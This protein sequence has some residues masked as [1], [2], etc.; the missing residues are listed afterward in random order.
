MDIELRSPL[1]KEDPLQEMAAAAPSSA[2]RPLYSSL[3]FLL[4][5]VRSKKSAFSPLSIPPQ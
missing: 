5:R 3:N 2:H 4:Q 1:T